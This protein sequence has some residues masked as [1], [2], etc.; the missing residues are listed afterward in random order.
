M[1]VPI[2]P[3][4]AILTACKVLFRKRSKGAAAR[5]VPTSVCEPRPALWQNAV[6]I[7]IQQADQMPATAVARQQREMTMREKIQVG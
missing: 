1:H 5:E 3:V 7:A 6:A 2:R 4:S